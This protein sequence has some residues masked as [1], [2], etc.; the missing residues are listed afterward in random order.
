[1]RRLPPAGAVAVALAGFTLIELILVILI[2]AALAVFALPKLVDTTLWRLRAFGDDMQGQMQSML[3]LSLLQRRP[4]VA[5]ITGSGISFAYAGGGALGSLDCP[6]GTSPCIA[7]GGSRSISFNNANTGS[8][9]SSS[10]A[11]LPIT[12]AAGSYSQVYRLENETG[13]I[14]PLP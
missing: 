10:A 5:T 7:E 13:L 9:L 8:A 3:R 2:T 14:Y 12:V 6:A 1:M 11:A 4:V